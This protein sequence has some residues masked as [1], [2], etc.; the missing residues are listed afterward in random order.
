MIEAKK[1]SELSE[2]KRQLLQLMLEEKR[3]KRAQTVAASEE[4]PATIPRRE[5]FSPAPVSFAQQRLWFIDQLDPGTPI[6]NIPA[7]IRMRGPL[8]VSC[9]KRSVDEILRRHET[10]RTCFGTEKGEPVQ[11]IAE[12][13][14]LEVSLIDLQVLPTEE[15]RLE[16][17]RDLV[18][19]DCQRSFDLT[20]APLV[21]TSLVRLGEGDHVLL[22]M[23]QHIVGDV[24]SVRVFMKELANLYQ[25]YLSGK[26]SP[27]AELPVQYAD[28]AVWQRNWLQGKVLEEQLDYWRQ[29]LSGMPEELHLPLDRPRPPVQSIW[30]AKHFLQV[31]GAVSDA[32]RD[33]GREEGASAFM[34]LLG[35]WKIV[36]SRYTGQDDI[37]VGIPAA[38][39]NRSEFEGMVGF[40]VNSVVLRTKLSG[41]STFRQLLARQREVTLGAFSH[42]DFP[43]ERLVE[44]L[45]PERDMSK[46]PLFQTDFILQNAPASV[47]EVPAMT[48]E[49]L[50]VE[51][52]TAQLDMTLDL[53]EEGESIGGW[54]EYDVDLFDGTT[55]M[56]MLR[57]F[58]SVLETAVSEPDRP[59]ESLP[60]SPRAERQML[61]AEWNA[62]GRDFD[63]ET[64]FP[65]LFTAQARRTPEVVA[66][67]CGEESWTYGE[68]ESRAR[69][70]ATHLATLGVGVDDTVAVLAPRGLPFLAAILGIQQAGAAYLPLDPLHPGNRHSRILE[71]G[72]S[73]VALATSD[74]IADLAEAVATLGEEKRPRV[75][76]LDELLQEGRDNP[77]PGSSS[78][79]RILPGSLAYV[80]FTSGSTGV[81]KGVMIH[82]RGLVN[83][84][85]A[86]LDFLSMGSEDVLAQTANQCFDIS[87][88]QFL[89]PLVVGGRVHIFPDAVTH[90]PPRL[91]REVDAAAV[92]VFETVPSLLRVMLADVE[93]GDGPKPSLDS[94]RWLLPTGEALPP[95]L[96]RRWFRSYP[97]IPLVNAY[98]PSECSDDVT[99]QSFSRLREMDRSLASIGR[100]VANLQVHILDRALR[101][102]PL[103]VSG[104]LCVGG[105]G[106][107]R[108][109]LGDPARTALV[110]VPNP[111]SSLP[112]DRLYRS[113][114]LARFLADGRLEFV[115]RIDFQVKVRGFRIELGEI[116]AAL[117]HHPAVQEAVVLARQD[118]PGEA[119][120][121]AYFVA[122]GEAPSHAL[123]R[124]DLLRDL[125]EYMVPSAFVALPALPL[126]ASGKVDRKALPAPEGESSGTEPFVAP[127]T[128]VEEVLAGIWAEIL[129]RESLN[130]EG[131]LFEAGA[132]SLLL[133][134][135]LSRV[136]TAFEVE[137]PLRSFFETPTVA[138]MAASV[139]RLRAVAQGPQA[140]PIERVDRTGRLPLSFTQERMWFLDQLQPGLT[141]YNVPGAVWMDGELSFRALEQGLTEIIRR[142]EIFR[143]TYASESGLPV[144]VIHRPEPF[145][146][147]LVDL[148]G[149]PKAL[150][151]PLAL[152][153]A[154][155]GARH[156]FDLEQGPMLRVFLVRC[157]YRAHRLAMTTHHIAYD[158][159]AREIFIN[160]LGQ[161]YLAF[162]AGQPSPLREQALHFVDFAAWQ[163][164]WLQGEELERQLGYWSQ[165]L[166]GVPRFLEL[167]TDRPRPP[168]QSFLGKRQYILLPAD[169]AARAHGLS[170]RLG[171]TPFITVLAAFKLLLQRYAGVDDVVV[172]SPIANRGRVELE[173]VM[174]FVANTVV[175]AT[176]LAGEPTFEEVLD[177][178]RETALGAYSHQDVPFESLVQE[179]A[180]ERDMSRS[181]LFQVMFNFML[182][183]KPPQVEL[184]GLRLEVETLHGGGA[185]FDLNVDMFQTPEGLHGVIEY[186][187]DIYCDS[188][189]TRMMGQFEALLDAAVENPKQHI[190]RLPLLPAA[191]RLQLI[192][193]WNDTSLFEDA[194]VMFPE[195]FKAQAARTPSSVAAT[196]EGD[197]LT[198]QELASRASGIAGFLEEQGIGTDSVVPILARRNLDLLTAIVGVQEA[199]AAYLPLDPDHPAERHARILEQ[200]GARLLL[201]QLDL[202]PLASEA[203]TASKGGAVEVLVLEDLSGRIGAP[204]HGSSRAPSP[205]P[206]QGS[207]ALPDSLAYVLFTSGSTGLPKGVMV[208]HRGLM[209]HL[210]AN[211][212]HLEM[213]A[214]DVLA[215]TAK[216]CFDISVW[217]FLAPLIVGG[218]V[219]IFPDEIAHDP[220]RLIRA[221]DADQVTVLETVPSLLQL[222]LPQETGRDDSPKL[223]ALRW[224]LPTGEALPVPLQ[225][226]WLEHYPEIP[227]VNAYGPSECSDDVTLETLRQPLPEGVSAVPIG[228]PVAGLTSYV[229]DRKLRVQGIGMPGEICVGGVGVGRG[230]LSDPRRTAEVFIP[231]PFTGGGRRIYRSGD[232]GRTLQDG[233]LEYLGRLDFQVKVRGFRIELGEIEA[234]LGRHPAVR[235]AVV[236]VRSAPVGGGLDARLVAYVVPAS[237]EELEQEALQDFLAEHLPAYMA[238]SAL[239]VL[240]AFPLTRNGKV[241][242]DALP[243]PEWGQ[244]EDDRPFLAPRDPEEERLAEIFQEVLGL[245]AVSVDVDFFDMGG[246]SLLAIQVLSRIRDSFGVEPPLRTLFETS[247]VAGMAQVVRA[248]RWATLS[249]EEAQGELEDGEPILLEEGVL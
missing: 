249:L 65:D 51:N 61:R 186:A 45:Q 105:V 75:V 78:S 151:E 240:D 136:R 127:R 19:R 58:L 243:D 193:E 154:K 81:P 134:Q 185:Q 9:F 174:G 133:T 88:W 94:L 160:E 89:A 216:Q 161:L 109:Y 5:V 176:D 244:P 107:G 230:Y 175:L 56:R 28:Y 239:L 101:P 72:G 203:S 248:I 125:P 122:T 173:Q 21:R 42:Q 156:P 177:R 82:H 246:H 198:Y 99:L 71:S 163:R 73:P 20:Q 117:L 172:G 215:Q 183:Y 212:D 34:T 202:A 35:A 225:R 132:H 59:L 149:L 144:Q 7:S 32:V 77:S 79:P 76:D 236:A 110:F 155:A 219:A 229:L 137:L 234:V 2:R 63:L 200:S 15:A 37:V 36:L 221:V 84:L 33:L 195:A 49:A 140:P 238:P 120:L 93:D 147:P 68:L 129:G 38:N 150:R 131:N 196:C 171:M 241:D 23:L 164:D 242:R 70:L 121:V 139:E 209:N 247:T 222:M 41:V 54:L 92:T 64:S 165:K 86:N 181:P 98:G 31:P 152:D 208:H 118:T 143:T 14:R 11:V 123:F 227:L 112:G 8:N 148:T 102:V 145:C 17:V 115:G 1:P 83:H 4:R 6:F 10:L 179:L 199:G 168:M 27:L 187:T 130:V 228:R 74:L 182:H 18:T 220:P 50:P 213:G 206:S 205:G 153:L 135:V 111:C 100:P 207:R 214:G 178:V 91:L 180:P 204:S 85:W 217:Q 29:A 233:R 237:G 226:R 67:I 128:P 103:G 30:G 189:I 69:G 97:R 44:L 190:S 53:W 106:V 162:A 124:E 211:L 43:F 231:D 40:F 87:V 12:D 138:G 119:R 116:E 126:N 57:S 166:D 95:E 90:D 26:P 47:Y 141:A 13:V 235:E 210:R 184:P 201:A 46:N 223:E 22:M 52:G 232:L 188:T 108:G 142:H 218:R 25:A 80:L 16:V 159:W 169:L 197:S 55:A 113:G 157:G 66:A 245:D 170:R 224:M 39:R 62:T 24:W 3:R 167:P 158:M 146:L 60:T 104:E 114:D 96:G 192:E 191:Q 194:D 48:F